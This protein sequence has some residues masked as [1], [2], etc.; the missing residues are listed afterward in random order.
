MLGA[1][2]AGSA[3]S[4]IKISKTELGVTIHHSSSR[5]NEESSKLTMQRNTLLVVLWLIAG[6]TTCTTHA[7]HNITAALVALAPVS[8]S[9]AE[10]TL[11]LDEKDGNTGAIVTVSWILLSTAVIAQFLFTPRR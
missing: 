8:D 7:R 10:A 5:L 6:L 11:T 9:D 1:E 2:K 3:G 4:E